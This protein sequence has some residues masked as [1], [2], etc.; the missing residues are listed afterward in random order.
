MGAGL[1]GR[2]EGPREGH[3]RITAESFRLL[4]ARLKG[5]RLSP[6]HAVPVSEP[7][8]A[9]ETFWPVPQIPEVM[10]AEPEA[11]ASEPFLPDPVGE[12]LLAEA[13]A[14]DFAPLWPPEDFSSPADPVAEIPDDAPQSA[15]LEVAPQAGETLPEPVDARPPLL[16]L[17]ER[18]VDAMLQTVTEAI[19][20]K[21]TGAERAAF[22]REIA[23]LIEEGGNGEEALGS[24]PQP[25]D[26]SPEMAPVAAPMI[27][28]PTVIEEPQDITET[29]ADKLG[30][31]TALLRKQSDEPDPFSKTVKD[32]IRLAPQPAETPEADEDSGDLALSL[33]DMMSS[34]A[35][36]LP[37]E[38]ALAAD[39]LLRMV[40]RVPVRQLIMVTERIAIME[41]PP[42]LL[43]AKLIRDP[44]AEVVAPLLERCMHITDQDLMAAASEGDSTKR[45]MM[46]RRRVLSPVLADHL[47]A[48]GDPST[49]L[50]LIRNPGAAFS[51]EAFYRLAGEA[52]RHHALLAPLTTRAD[53]PAPVAFELFWFVPQELRRFILSR[54]LTDSEMLS[55]I[56]K[57][58]L[59]AQDGGE[60]KFPARELLE[61]VVDNA[62]RGEIEEAARILA[63]IGGICQETAS[64]ILADPHG[65][66]VSVLLKALGYPRANFAEAMERFKHSGSQI[67][68]ADRNVA[69]LE[70]IFDTLSFNKARIL[71]TYW[72]WFVQKSGPYAPQ[73]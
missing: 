19:Y 14:S 28:P 35:S 1:D 49:L 12:V 62:A 5:T 4:T 2:Q 56:L 39:T 47:I 69:E 63:E 73:N 3:R 22:L 60:T 57:I 71:L 16:P 36:A 8:P 58:T 13:A 54:F 40:P 68:R 6:G 41:A 65:E 9:L 25:M 31:S 70:S 20:A 15:E 72:D 27:E 59:G 26:I 23:A 38:R 67:L 61:S 52:S 43:V 10:V 30:S 55:K 64:R 24:V 45:R 34:G 48:T 53:L 37:Q 33:L 18:V 17:A 46:A 66:P 50:T 29:L 21:P 51:H 11:E 42:A 44:R 7:P 32:A